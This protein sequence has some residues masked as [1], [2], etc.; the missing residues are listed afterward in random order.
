MKLIASYTPIFMVVIGIIYPCTSHSLVFNGHSIKVT[1]KLEAVT[2]FFKHS[3]NIYSLCA[4]NDDI[5]CKIGK[6][7]GTTCKGLMNKDNHLLIIGFDE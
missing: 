7:S 1:L 4:R 5:L 2:I 6:S 3:D